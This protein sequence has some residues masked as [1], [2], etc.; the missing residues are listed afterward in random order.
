MFSIVGALL[1]G[2]TAYAVFSALTMARK[3]MN[4]ELL[5][6]FGSG[7]FAILIYVVLGVFLFP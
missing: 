1:A 6:G 7:L 2:I 5:F 4:T 3:G